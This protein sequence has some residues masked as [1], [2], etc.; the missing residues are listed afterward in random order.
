MKNLLLALFLVFS[1]GF[2]AFAQTNPLSTNVHGSWSS[3]RKPE[4]RGLEITTAS[5][6]TGTGATAY[7]ADVD[8]SES[9]QCDITITG[10]SATVKLQGKSGSAG[11]RDIS[12]STV[13]ADQHFTIFDK[14]SA[15]RGNVTA[16]SSCNV[17]IYCDWS[18]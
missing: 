13:T 16:C 4:S 9:R 2:G 5:G 18:Y 10:T 1:M 15:I 8:G 11:W 3:Q 17:V 12:G 6:Q 7:F 14:F